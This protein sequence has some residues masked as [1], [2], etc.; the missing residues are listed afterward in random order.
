MMVRLSFYPVGGSYLLVVVAALV[1]LGLLAVGPTGQRM[2]GRRRVALGGLRLAVIVLLLLAMLRP[3]LVYTETTRKSATVIVLADGSRSMSVSDGVGG[4]TRWELLRRSVAD[5]AGALGKLA[6]DFEVK[7]YTFDAEP[8]PVEFMDGKIAL[9]ETPQGRQTAIGSVLEDVLR[10]EAGKRLLG[11]IL[12]S[13]GAQ[14]AYAPR[15]VA[16]QTAAGQLKRLGYPL[17]TFP[18]GQARGLGQAQ[19]VAVKNLAVD[20]YVFVKNELS[21]AGAVRVDGYDNRKIPVQLFFETSPGKMEAVAQQTLEATAKGQLMPVRMSYVPQV[22]G[23]YKLTLEAVGQ[24]GELVTTNNS[25]STFVNVLAGGLNV[26]YVEGALRV[27]Q[28][29]VRRSLDASPDINVDYVRLDPRRPKTRP[30]DFAARFK[31]GRYEVY[32][33]GDID[34]TAFEPSELKDLAET[35]SRGAGLIMLGGFHS[36]GPGGY[37]STPLADVLPV[38]MTRF[39]RQN[40]DEPIRT[41]LHLPG[42]I[43][44]QP[45]RLG[46]GHFALTLGARRQ[47][48]QKAWT[49]LPP[50]EGANRFG[51]PKLGALVLAEAGQNNPLLV[52]QNYGNGRVMALAVD[53]TWRWWMRGYESAHK[54]F[55]RQ[56]VLWL[57]RKD[58]SSQGDV[59]I[60]LPKRRFSPLERVEFTMGA[61]SPTGE[62]V[63]DAQ[64]QVEVELPDDTKRS[65]RP[66]QR[67]EQTTGSFRDTQTPGDYAIRVRATHAGQELGTARSRFLVFEQDLELDNAA[68]DVTTLESLSAMTGGESF[69]PE[70]LPGLLERLVHQSETLQTRTETKKTLWDTWPFLLAFVCLI[71]IEWYLRKHWGLV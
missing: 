32:I 12:L 63:T 1:L 65:V 39:Q 62:P 37:S 38:K 36:F 56:I 10:L 13:D 24:P 2:N 57:A 15:D 58:E 18:F 30:P 20:Q 67:E 51:E 6:E 44:M 71:G 68:A 35:V 52:S 43:R 8:H 42:P 69:A 53:S 66:V 47:E 59:W 49:A 7:A 3:T 55:W 22:P 5:A 48:N 33:L 45:T 54:R 31:P 4:K 41:D 16:P 11:V 70:Q 64:F 23:E 19:D 21:I 25:L 27:E 14:R 34:S 17:F 28:K 61:Q 60:K 40:F 50:L 26:L 29:F 46:L 9:G